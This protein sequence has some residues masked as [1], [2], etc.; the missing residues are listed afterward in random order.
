MNPRLK[1]IL[2]IT[3]AMIP[4]V[5]CIY[6][7]KHDA[8]ELS[9]SVQII[10]NANYLW[11][12]LALLLTAA[13]IF[14]FANMYVSSFRALKARVPFSKALLLCLKRN[15]ISVFL[16]AG[17]ITSLAF[18]TAPIEKS[19][20]SKTKIHLASLMTGISG[21]ISLILVSLP[22]LIILLVTHELNPVLL[23]ALILL[24]LF[25]IIALFVFMSFVRGGW[26]FLLIKNRIPRMV[27][28]Y[29]ELKDQDIRLIFFFR[30]ILFSFML[31]MIGI[32]H[33]FIVM[34]ALGIDASLEIAFI[35]YVAAT[36]MLTISP[37]M[38][39]LGA[40]EI[41]LTLI[42]IKNG[43]PSISAISVT[44]LYRIFEFWLVLFTGAMSFFYKKDNFLLRVF[45]SLLVFILGIVNILSVLTPALAERLKLLENFVPSSAIYVSNYTVIIAGI[46]LIVLS[47]FLIRGLK[48]AWRLTVFISAI[49]VIGHL[50][51]AIDYE[52]AVFGG[53]VIGILWYT[54]NNYLVLS[55]KKFF[56]NSLY[57]L[58][59][60][61]GFILIYGIIGLYLIDTRHFHINFSLKQSVYYLINTAF[62]FNNGL[63]Q[64][65][66]D[67]ARWFIDS[68]NILGAAFI[69]FLCY[70]LFKPSNYSYKSEETEKEA[71]TEMVKKYGNSSLDYFKLYSDKL[72]YISS[73]VDG[74]ISFKNAGDYA[75]VLEM[76]V[77]A[78]SAD[79][80]AIINEFDRHCFENG[81]KTIYY[82]VDAKDLSVFEKTGKKTMFLGQEGIIDTEAFKMEGGDMKPTR[83]MLHRLEKDGYFCRI[84]EPPVKDGMIQKLKAVSDEWL[85]SFDKREAVFSG[86]VFK[87]NELKMQTIFTIENAEEKVVAFANIIPDYAPDEGT[88]DLIRKSTDAPKGV[89]DLLLVEMISYF[90]S[91]QIRYINVGLAPMSGLQKGKNLPEKT[92]KFAYENLKQMQH[93][94]GLRFFKEK[95]ATHWNDKYIVYN[96]DYDLIQLPFVISK[97]SKYIA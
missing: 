18:F 73:K 52:E 27:L 88:Y 21:I 54:R 37:F 56:K 62:L 79:S 9:Q 34:K 74:F 91:Q 10:K 32:A 11:L 48:N 53:I 89:M 25:V 13:Y 63:L 36:L 67:F 60:G 40:V 16:P 23:V 2:Q 70:V 15:F 55:D 49:S 35:G 78:N 65:H 4:I 86:G 46:V 85:S 81:L 8:V 57:Y 72:F 64:Q 22:A 95:Y 31:E 26:L 47:A 44:L 96:N 68:L 94:K 33:L 59:A 30:A 12:L 38:K 19:G 42:L 87:P 14:C 76:P 7:I 29:E 80:L 82:R 69:V 50:T 92:L 45:P 43:I 39:G 20:V 90:R 24:I 3:L 97:V 61:F 51:K 17:S 83:N 66:T 77:C 75:V 1:T 6:F 93:F 84:I 28:L 41:S 71:V 5:F 58:L